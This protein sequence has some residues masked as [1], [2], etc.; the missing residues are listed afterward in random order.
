MSLIDLL[1]II[2]IVTALVTGAIKGVVCQIGTIVAFVLGLL[3][4]RGFGPQ[5]ASYIVP[6]ESP[7]TQAWTWTVYFVL[8][9]LVFLGVTLLARMLHTTFANLKLNFINRLAGA[10][11][12]ATIWIISLS[13]LLN[14][15]FAVLPDY[16][17]KFCAGKPW[18]TAIVDAAPHLIGYIAN[19]EAS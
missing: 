1:L 11:L 7:Y 3:V 10:L 8:F 19:T 14:I 18:R 16:K 5:V 13:L 9:L 12:R 17:E 6:A 2:F 15:A 4:C